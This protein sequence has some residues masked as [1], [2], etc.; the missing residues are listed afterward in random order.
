MR[1]DLRGLIP[2]VLLVTAAWYGLHL[3]LRP[4]AEKPGWEFFPD[5][6]RSVAAESFASD[7]LL[8][9]GMVLQP[10]VAGVVLRE[11]EAFDFGPGPE[12]QK[13]AGLELRS[14]LAPGDPAAS[15]RGEQIYRRFCIVCHAARGDGQGSVVARGMLPPPSL[16]GARALG[17]S[18]GEMFHILTR[19][20]GNMASHAAQITRH[21]RWAVIAYVRNL[22]GGGVK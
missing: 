11:T 3:L 17:L 19:G 12:E 18:D 2:T 16:L 22:Q 21:D 10:P 15:A 6:A 5:M 1:S 9:G 7:E 13:R 8:P 20:Q 4:Q 14:P